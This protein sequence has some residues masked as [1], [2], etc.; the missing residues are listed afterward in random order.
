MQYQSSIEIRSL[1]HTDFDTLFQGFERAFSDYEIHFEREEVRS[2]LKRR[3]YDARLSF[4][5][6]VNG[7]IVAFTLNGIGNF[8]GIPTAYD[9]ATGT[10]KEYRGQGLAGKIFEYSIPYLKEADIRQYLLEVLQSNSKAIG[11]YRSMSFNVVREFDCFR[12]TIADL[13]EAKPAGIGCRIETVGADFV[14]TSQSFCDFAPSWQ[15]SMESIERG[16]SGL[17]F[18]GA[19][20]NE[21]P[22]GYCVFDPCS[23]DLTQLAVKKEFRRRGIASQL[24]NEAIKHMKTGFVKVINVDA[25]CRSLS[26][27]LKNRNILPASKQYEMQLEL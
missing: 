7:D 15:N 3:G 24:L 10:V 17:Q 13:T 8:N 11:L 25:D 1:E 22:A 21:T 16:E 12:Q 19:L 4:A 26:A 9:T 20:N 5:A 6:F 18:L 14:R 2:M 27:F 23:G